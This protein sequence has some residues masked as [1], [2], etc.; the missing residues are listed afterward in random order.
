MWGQQE[1][2]SHSGITRASRGAQAVSWTLRLPKAGIFRGRKRH[3]R[4]RQ[5]QLALGAPGKIWAKSYCPAG[6]GPFRHVARCMN[7]LYF[8]ISDTFS[9]NDVIKTF[10]WKFL[11]GSCPSAALRCVRSCSCP[12]PCYSDRGPLRGWGLSQGCCRW[13]LRGKDDICKGSRRLYVVLLI[14]WKFPFSML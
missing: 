10:L 1:P 4:E 6:N 2:T 3:L 8:K 11:A 14:I 5:Y 7:S 13:G 9:Q 12:H